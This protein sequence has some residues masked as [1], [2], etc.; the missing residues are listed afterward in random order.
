[1]GVE[2][3]CAVVDD[4]PESVEGA[5]EVDRVLRHPL[6]WS[7]TGSGVVV[8]R[9]GS[10]RGPGTLRGSCGAPG[11]FV[12]DGARYPAAGRATPQLQAGSW[13]FGAERSEGEVVEPRGMVV[14]GR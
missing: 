12:V 5:G 6:W 2:G 13:G 4:G 8:E 11:V 10:R 9:E 1:M 7:S 3:L 14:V